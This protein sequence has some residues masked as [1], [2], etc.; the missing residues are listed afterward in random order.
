MAQSQ[1][2][3]KQGD[4]IRLG[5]AV[6]K[7][8]KKINEIKNEEN[9]LYLPEEYVYKDVKGEITTRQELNRFINSLRRFNMEGAE[10]LY[11]TDAGELLT[12]WERKEL[13]INSRII[14]NRLKKELKELNEPGETGY[15]RVQMGSVREKAIKA[16]LENSKKIEQLSGYE[17]KNLKRRLKT[18]G[19]S[20]Y[21]MKKAITYKENY[22]N[23]IEI[24]SN[25]D[26]YDKLITKLKSIQNPIDFYNFVS[27]NELLSDI[28]YM[29]EMDGSG[30]IGVNVQ[31]GFNNMLESVGIDIEEDYE[32]IEDI[33]ED[34]NKKKK[35]KYKYSLVT[36]SGIIVAQSDSK[37]TLKNIALNSK[38]VEIANAYIVINY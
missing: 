4:Y 12:K 28:T 8:N 13:G 20:D 38:D 24:Y 31:E 23:M 9:K 5:Q 25:F 27:K 15:S 33:E 35:K 34:Y 37:T 10:E 17:F 3:W 18:S 19:T 32:D 11:K 22:L 6:A 36:R 21:T 2:K 30:I 14:Q 7:F 26:N 1:I 16:Q 29:Y